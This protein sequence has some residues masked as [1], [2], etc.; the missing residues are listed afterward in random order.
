MRGRNVVAT[1]IL[2]HRVLFDTVVFRFSIVIQN[3]YMIISL[4]AAAFY[5]VPKKAITVTPQ[6]SH[7]VR[8]AVSAAGTA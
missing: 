3:C 1:K 5:F 4:I 6:T 8:S 7:A 2:H